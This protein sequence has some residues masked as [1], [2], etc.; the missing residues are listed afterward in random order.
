MSITLAFDVYDTLIDTQDISIKLKTMVGPKA[1]DFSQLWRNKQ[2]EYSFRR[3]L[4]QQYDSFSMC[5]M[6][7]LDYC[8]LH[9]NI[10][11]S[12]NQKRVLLD[13][14]TVL[15]AFDDVKDSLQILSDNGI[16][17][18]AFS[19]GSKKAVKLLLENARLQKYFLDVIS[20]EDVKSFKPSPD[21]Y[22]HLVHK[23]GSPKSALYLVSS[24]PFDVIGALSFS[25]KAA[26]LKRSQNAVFDPW[27]VEPTMTISSLRDLFAKIKNM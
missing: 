1:N 7:A 5:I 22:H 21:V 4:M 6:Q 15:P 17:L 24:N 13:A 26:W 19:N 20:V 12:E 9:Y 27:G 18:Y 10:L 11:L 8:C 16:R 23:T 14:Y 25:V 3:G 2:L